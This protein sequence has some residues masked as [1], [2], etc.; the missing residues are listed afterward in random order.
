VSVVEPREC[1]G[2]TDDQLL[3]PPVSLSDTGIDADSKAPHPRGTLVMMRAGF[4]GPRVP[5]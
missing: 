2:E 1:P 5:G 3:Y 4:A